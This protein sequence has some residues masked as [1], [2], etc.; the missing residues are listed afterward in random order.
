[1]KIGVIGL[2]YWGPNIVRNFLTNKNVASVVCC[3]MNLKRLES[4]RQKFPTIET[5]SDYKAILK[6]PSVVA[7]AIVTPVS[8][9][10]PLAKEALEAGKHVLLE[11]PMTDSSARARELIALAEKKKLTL[12]VDHTFIYTGAVQKIKELVTSGELGDILYFDSVRVNLGLFQHDVNVIWD[13]A[14][15][16]VSIMDYV[17]GKKPISVSAVGVSHY[18]SIEDVAY[19]TVNFEE[20]LIAHFHVNWL[21]PVKVRK[22]LIGGSKKMI[23]YDDVDQSDKVKIY[24][25]GINIQSEE[26][27]HKALVQYRIGDMYAPNLD[28][29]E[30]LAGMVADFI[31]SIINDHKPQSDGAA[32]LNVVRILEASQNSLRNK[33]AVISLVG[34]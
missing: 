20:N 6:N 3:D 15:H 8:T 28:Q 29:T 16:D 30:A 32:G 9:H 19:L 1:M 18:N 34:D 7:V 2:G 24:D 25:K 23:V 27:V 4:I 17:I 26:M 10:Y 11:K 22:M 21:S 5:V 13:L 33:S 31:D 12:M 14:P